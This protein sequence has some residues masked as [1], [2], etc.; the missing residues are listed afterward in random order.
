MHNLS[1]YSMKREL[2]TV[3]ATETNFLRPRIAASKGGVNMKAV[4]NLS[5][6]G[7][8]WGI[9]DADDNYVVGNQQMKFNPWTGVALPLTTDALKTSIRLGY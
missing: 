4:I 7:L 5:N 6:H 3:P 9:V 2:V 8:C 1:Q